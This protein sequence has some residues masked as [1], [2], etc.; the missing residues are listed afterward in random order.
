MLV[1]GGNWNFTPVSKL[2]I[3]VQTCQVL[4]GKRAPARGMMRALSPSPRISM[5]DIKKQRPAD[6]TQDCCSDLEVP[7]E[8][9]VIYGSKT[10]PLLCA[11]KCH[12]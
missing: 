12:P 1:G 7:Q 9:E 10:T 5:H 3:K 6:L 2:E 11:N 4:G 8:S